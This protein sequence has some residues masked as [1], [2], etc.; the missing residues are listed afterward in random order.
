MPEETADTIA[1]ILRK[2]ADHQTLKGQRVEGR[3]III[4]PQGGL[5]DRFKAAML[6]WEDAPTK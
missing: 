5:L 1:E 6:I 2:S 3:G 4:Q